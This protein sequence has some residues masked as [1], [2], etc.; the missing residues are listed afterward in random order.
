METMYKKISQQVVVCIGI[1]LIAVSGCTKQP[2]NLPA[3]VKQTSKGYQVKMAEFTVIFPSDWNGSI[4][5]ETNQTKGR[6]ARQEI[7]ASNS[8][9][10]IKLRYY[11]EH[12]GWASY[13]EWVKSYQR[14]HKGENCIIK[15]TQVGKKYAATMFICRRGGKLG[16]TILVDGHGST[17][18]VN[19]AMNS[20]DDLLT[21]IEILNSLDINRDK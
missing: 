15:Q 4:A 5:P 12:Y 20:E 10:D 19:G 7:Y 11:N 17:V 14:L 16:F 3:S 9:I 21:V 1:I 8:R 2:R 13:N 18:I 6:L